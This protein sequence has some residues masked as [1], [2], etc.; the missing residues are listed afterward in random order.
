M[1]VSLVGVS[2]P[3]S[4]H[5]FLANLLKNTL[6]RDLFYC[7]FYSE[8]HCCRR[9]PCVRPQQALIT[10]QKNHD[11]DLAIDPGLPD[12]RYLVQY[13]DPV[14]AVVSDRELFAEVRGSDI[15]HNTAQYR[16]VLGEKAA[17]YVRFYEKWVRHPH[18]S[19]FLMK[20]EWL[21]E[22]PADALAALMR[23]CGLEIAP[24]TIAQAVARV[25]PV[26][27]RPPI[28]KDIGDVAFTRRDPARS[29]YFDANLLAVYESLVL[30]RVP[31]LS[32]RRVFAPVG[33]ANHPLLAMFEVQC[34]RLD[35]RHEDAMRPALAALEKSPDDPYVR[36]VAAECLRETG[37]TTAGL[38]CLNQAAEMAPN[39]AQIVG[40]CVSANYQ[41]G[42]I[43]RVSELLARL[44]ALVPADPGCRLFHASILL[45]LDRPEQALDRALDAVR[46]GLHDN[47]H[48][49]EFANIVREGRRRGW[50]LTVGHGAGG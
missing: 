28:V 3:R 20:Y 35:G 31:E 26:V 10:Y 4:G 43:E 49:Q 9:V 19:R 14:P 5:H 45:Q 36:F 13:R 42:N 50:A 48:W 21:L 22:E 32:D 16:M 39:D 41:Q 37:D 23:F 12:V 47:R 2:I 46:V 33:Y 6:G 25:A 17:H 40:A 29:E 18:G 30:D 11:Q 1:G 27:N 15:A 44:S 38:V 8:T 34:A 24:D 7:E